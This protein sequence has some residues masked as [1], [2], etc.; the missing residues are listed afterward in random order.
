MENLLNFFLLS[1]TSMFALMNP[2]NVMP[3]YVSMTNGLT[4]EKKK[5]IV[6]KATFTAFL[7]LLTFSLGG[8]LIFK[9][10]GISINSFKIAGGCIFFLI[11]HDMLQARITKTKVDSEDEKNYADDISITPLAIPMICGPGAITNAI[12][13]MANA[14]DTLSKIVLII[15]II[16]MGLLTYIILRQ[17]DKISRLLGE[18]GNKVMMRLM[19]LIIMV[20]AIEFFFSGLKP[21]LR[22]IFN[23]V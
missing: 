18:T 16:V 4:A 15:A 22:D 11:G 5:Y 14:T 21:I 2:L 23:I 8:Q 13:L 6:K 19:G 3:I 9:F 12:V 20:I 1:L 10:F 17:A 7:A